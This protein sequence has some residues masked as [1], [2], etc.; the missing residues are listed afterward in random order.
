MANSYRE[1]WIQDGLACGNSE[2]EIHIKQQFTNP[3]HVID[4]SVVKDYQQVVNDL[5][6]ENMVLKADKAEAIEALENLVNACESRTDIK[7][8]D[9]RALIAKLR[10][11][12]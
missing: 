4:Y 8:P 11:E 10:G 2:F 9:N 7:L 6:E 12:K 5:N 1:F 3:I